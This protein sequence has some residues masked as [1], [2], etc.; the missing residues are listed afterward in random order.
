MTSNMSEAVVNIATPDALSVEEAAVPNN[1][2]NNNN[3]NNMEDEHQIQRPIHSNVSDDPTSD[4]HIQ[5]NTT[6][7][8]SSSSNNNSVDRVPIT[9]KSASATAA[10]DSD[11]TNGSSITSSSS[12]T[13]GGDGGGGDKSNDDNTQNN[14]TKKKGNDADINKND[15]ST[16]HV[17]FGSVHVHEHRMTLGSN[18]DVSYGVP[19]ELAW[20]ADASDLFDSIEEFEQKA[21]AV[22]QQS[23]EQN[24]NTAGTAI[25]DGTTTTTLTTT[26][27]TT[28]SPPTSPS[29]GPYPHPVHRLKA[30]DRD[31]IA[32]RN[33]SRDSIVRVKQEV[34][35]IQEQRHDSKRDK[36]AIN[37]I[38]EI[39]RQRI[40]GTTSTTTAT[41]EAAE[42]ATKSMTMNRANDKTTHRSDEKQRSSLLLCCYC[43]CP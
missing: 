19:V 18:P 13:A 30:S 37:I 33:H 29:V 8:I 20:S 31:A 1:I 39:R 11:R 7:T 32:S 25:N 40:E 42:A 35:M 4:E 43:C 6:S 10:A 28:L 24:S 38:K 36:E 12:S 34:Q 5:S 17:S 26:T 16:S 23:P 14:N 27:A 2:P 9:T 21:H 22:T 41:S 15:V 3:N